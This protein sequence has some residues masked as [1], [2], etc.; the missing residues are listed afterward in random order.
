MTGFEPR[1][2]GIGSDRST[3][4]ATTTAQRLNVC[5][6]A[7]VTSKKS[8]NVYKSCLKMI[9][10]EKLKILTPLQKLPKNVIDLCKLIF[11]TGFE[12]LPK[13]Q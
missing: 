4:W 1:T 5:I 2:S 10:L 7:N 6:A 8:P 9:S 13:V 12:K 11:A 3:N